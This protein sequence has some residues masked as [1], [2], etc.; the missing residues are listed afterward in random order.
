M[1]NHGAEPDIEVWQTPEDEAAG[2]DAQIEAAV[3][4][5]LQRVGT[6]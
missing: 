1:E 6:R 4:E 3:K 5:L 2:R